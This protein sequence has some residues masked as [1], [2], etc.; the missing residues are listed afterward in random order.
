MQSILNHAIIKFIQSYIS[1]VFCMHQQNINIRFFDSL[2]TW[3]CDCNL[4]ISSTMMTTHVITTSNKMSVCTCDGYKYRHID[5]YLLRPHHRQQR[6]KSPCE[7]PQIGKSNN[8]DMSAH[9][10]LYALYRAP[11]THNRNEIYRSQI[12]DKFSHSHT[13]TF[14]F[15]S[16]IIIIIIIITITECVMC[17]TG[18]LRMSLYRISNGTEEEKHTHKIKNNA[19]NE[20]RMLR[21][22]Q[23]RWAQRK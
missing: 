11:C 1:M 21:I 4:C 14:S 17:E 20:T 3:I 19:E 13:H 9:T 18:M 16:L 5:I 15:I 10:V 12:P 2:T 8:S 22:E 23:M 7:K 6:N